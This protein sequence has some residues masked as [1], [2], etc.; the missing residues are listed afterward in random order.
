M[1]RDYLLQSS[2]ITLRK[3]HPI[4]MFQNPLGS[5]IEYHPLDVTL[6]GISATRHGI[7][8]A[9]VAHYR[10]AAKL[11]EGPCGALPSIL[12]SSDQ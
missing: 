1:I 8:L 10:V 9:S 3:Q 12:L 6:I 2:E 4:M 11:N 7:G 5:A